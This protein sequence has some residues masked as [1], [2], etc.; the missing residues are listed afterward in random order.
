[1]VAV[2][3]GEH[4]EGRRGENRG[5]ERQFARLRGLFFFF[6]TIVLGFEVGWWL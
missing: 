5:K 1:M 2:R 4:Y 6:L 3:R